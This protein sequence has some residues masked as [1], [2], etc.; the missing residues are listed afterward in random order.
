MDGQE[1]GRGL[2]I[3]N[4]LRRLANALAIDHTSQ[5]PAQRISVVPGFGDVEAYGSPKA[6]RTQNKIRLKLQG[7]LLIFESLFQPKSDASTG[8]KDEGKRGPIFVGDDL[9]VRLYFFF[10]VARSPYEVQFD[11][12]G[13]HVHFPDH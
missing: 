10:D 1:C 8:R 12:I 6:R 11:R 4:T 7:Q 3:K 2:R 5:L 9:T 13:C